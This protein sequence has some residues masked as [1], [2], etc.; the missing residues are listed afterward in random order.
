MP[1]P[2]AACSGVALLPHSSL[3]HHFFNQSHV[4]SYDLML[5][6]LNCLHTSQTRSFLSLHF[7][8]YTETFWQKEK[9]KS[10]KSWGGGAGI[11][12]GSSLSRTILKL[13]PSSRLPGVVME[14][15]SED[16][17]LQS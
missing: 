5:I 16:L 8:S 13:E 7:L 3:P 10:G 1:L 4:H 11:E 15:I 14:E 2:V 12:S 6:A 9:V 17:I